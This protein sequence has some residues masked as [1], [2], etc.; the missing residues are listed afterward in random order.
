MFKAKCYSMEDILSAHRGKSA[1]YVWHS[2]LAGRDLLVMDCNGKSGM[3]SLL[4]FGVTNGYSINTLV[5]F[6]C[7]T[8]SMLF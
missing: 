7:H 3:A 8:I 1:S 6:G 4:I 5:G 2:V